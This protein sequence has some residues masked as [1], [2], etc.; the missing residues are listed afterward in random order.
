MNYLHKEKSPDQTVLLFKTKRN[1]ASLCALAPFTQGMQSINGTPTAYVCE[2]FS[3]QA[4]TSHLYELSF[5]LAGDRKQN[6][7]SL[8]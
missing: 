3:C 1:E 4:P 7:D 6:D 5:L 8:L 2:I